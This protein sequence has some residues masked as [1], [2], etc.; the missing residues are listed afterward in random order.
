MRRKVTGLV[1]VFAMAM[2]FAA[3]GGNDIEDISCTLKS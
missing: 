3:C 2:A 1:M